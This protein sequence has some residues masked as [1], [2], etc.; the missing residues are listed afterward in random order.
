MEVKGW[1]LVDLL[2]NVASAAERLSKLQIKVER[3]AS[4]SPCLTNLRKK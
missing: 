1:I 3:E 4:L 2:K